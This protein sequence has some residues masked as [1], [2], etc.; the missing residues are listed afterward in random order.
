MAGRKKSEH[1]RE[2]IVRGAAEVF[3]RHEFH[4]VLTDDIAARIGVGKG[5]LYRYF[6][7]KEELYLAAIGD[8]LRELHT[9]VTNVLAQP[10]PLVPTIERLVTT[11][12]GYFW[13]KRDFF[14]LMHR[15]EPKLKAK[16]RAEWRQR[17]DEIVAMLGRRIDEAAGRGEIP[18][19]DSRLATEALLGMIRG[20][21]MYRQPGDRPQEVAQTITRLFL[22]GLLGPDSVRANTTS[23]RV[24]G[25]RR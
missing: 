4:E 9:S 20:A 12:I 15:L 11:L 3:S 19:V 25:V 23:R 16:E 18:R 7:S 10:S 24:A 1:I 13:D 14:V 17:R 22:S 2:A 21:C 5:T 6:R 8:G